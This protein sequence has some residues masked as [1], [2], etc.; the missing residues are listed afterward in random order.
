[1]IKLSIIKDGDKY[2]YMEY[3]NGNDP[4]KFNDTYGCGGFWDLGELFEEILKTYQDTELI[5]TNNLEQGSKK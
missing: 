1:M 5:I 3:Q 4:K 2:A